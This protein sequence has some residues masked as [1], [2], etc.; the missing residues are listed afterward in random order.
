VGFA[1]QVVP[2]EEWLQADFWQRQSASLRSGGRRAL[3][4][5]VDDGEGDLSSWLDHKVGCASY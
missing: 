1:R 5:L 2:S 3:S 4:A